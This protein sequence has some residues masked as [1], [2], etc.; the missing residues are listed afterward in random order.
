[1]TA[2]KSALAVK[3]DIA[4]VPLPPP[5]VGVPTIVQKPLSKESVTRRVASRSAAEYAIPE[6]A[7]RFSSKK[8]VKKEGQ[9]TKR[10]TRPWLLFSALV[11]LG[12]IGFAWT[13][14][15][16]R[17]GAFSNLIPFRPAESSTPIVVPLTHTPIATETNTSQPEPTHTR[18]VTPTRTATK[19]VVENTSTLTST[20]TLLPSPTSTYTPAPTNTPT[21]SPAGTSTQAVLSTSTPGQEL[22]NLPFTLYYNENSLYFHNRSNITRSISGFTFERL[23]NQGEVLNFFGGWDWGIYY[24]NITPNRCMAIELYLSPPFVRPADCI[25]PYLSKLGPARDDD[26]IFWTAQEN[27]SEFRVLWQEKEIGRCQIGAGIC[28]VF[29][30]YYAP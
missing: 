28:E 12:T 26:R 13:Q 23:D 8:P 27:S 14:G 15:W 2:L 22:I 1:M 17:T 10:F 3:K 5:P 25:Q 20:P 24:P 21:A 16:F 19:V 7:D 29:V 9:Q 11:L 4:K 18:T 6:E 30:P